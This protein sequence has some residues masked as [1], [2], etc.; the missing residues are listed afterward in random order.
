MSAIRP[1]CNA[2]LAGAALV[3]LFAI[4]GGAPG[5]L[6]AQTAA[7]DA[8]AE[9]LRP[10]VAK[11]LQAAG[12][13]I[14]AGKYDEALLQ[15]REAEHVPDQTAYEGY[16]INRMRGVAASGKGDALIATKSFEAVL[17]S[18]RSPRAEQLTLTEA[19]AVMYFKTGDYPKA[20]LWTRRY[21]TDGGANPE[22]RMQLVR[23]LYLADDFAGAAVEL[24]PLVDADERAGVPPLDRLQLLASCYVKLNDGAGYVLVLDKLLTYYPN[25]EYWAEAIRRVE[26]RPGFPEALRLDALRLQEATGTLASAAQYM[27]MAQLALKSGLPGEARRVAE[28]G[29]AA[30]VLG[31]GPDADAQRRLRDTAAKMAAA[32]EKTIA[33][34]ARDAGGAKDGT[35]LVNVGYAMVA[36]GQVDKGLALMEQGIRKGGI[37]QPDE[38]R[39]HLAI[40]YLAAG[41]KAK[42]IEAFRAVRG[43]GT[44][45]LARLW[46]I[47]AQRSSS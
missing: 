18:G 3:A 2:F 23:S 12:E 32:D 15:I 11:P 5:A 41:Q 28:Q 25:R 22:M 30:G 36:A 6:M 44:A 34:N 9:A 20:A 42:A 29:F 46:L 14:K 38:A 26:S 21:L 35:A 13:L 31:A 17:A 7:A 24:R 4:G 19:L 40:A 27:A 39:L 43:D 10:E 45:D 1:A 16:V 47:H 33:Q 8:S 37:S